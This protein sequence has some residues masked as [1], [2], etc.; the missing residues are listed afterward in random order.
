MALM[1][2]Q[3]TVATSTEEPTMADIWAVIE[4]I[5]MNGKG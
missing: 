3:S 5:I 1:T 2:A 4:S